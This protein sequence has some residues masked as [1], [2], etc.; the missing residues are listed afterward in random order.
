MAT[1]NIH[2]YH[3]FAAGPW[4]LILNQHMMAVCNY[5]L[6]EEL[7]EIRIGIVGPPE[8]RK[9]VKETLE[10]SLVAEK[11][12]IVVE[13]GMAWEQATLTELWKA[14]QTEDANYF[15]AH[16]KGAF[17]RALQKQLWCRSMIFF[18]VVAY[19]VCLDALQTHDAV[20]CHWIT[21]EKYPHM[22]CKTNTEGVPYFAGNFWWSK[23]EHIRQLPEP[24]RNHR[25]EAEFWIGM[26]EG[27]QI[28]DL[29]EGWPDLN[30]MIVTF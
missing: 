9:R 11:V 5:G 1:K 18:N 19:P 4:Q 22:V 14:A 8:A 6:M 25:F 26:K 16:T 13:R 23:S 24:P 28:K 10:A 3:V 7:D 21:A 17:D 12:K 30:K 20:G 29:N 2:Y 15:Y 27:M